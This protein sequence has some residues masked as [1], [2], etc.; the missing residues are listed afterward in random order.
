MLAGILLYAVATLWVQDRWAVCGLQAA[1]FLCT[2]WV[3]LR[4]ALWRLP[5]VGGVIPALFAGMCLWAVTQRAA[6]W[7]VVPAD[8]ADASL[9]WL[10][11]ACLAWL[12]LQACAA[13]QERRA[14]LKTALS[15]GSAV[16]LL[17]LV[18]LFTSNGLVFW[19]FPSGYD[20]G[21]VGPFVSR[22][23]YAALVELLLPV[24]LVLAFRRGRQAKVYWVLA[25]ALVAS[26]IASGSRAGTSIVLGEATLAFLLK[27]RT[28]RNSV[29]R[30]SM[31]FVVLVPAFTLIVGYQYVWQRLSGDKNPFEFRREFVESSVA[32]VRAEPLHGFGLGTWPSAYRQY[33]VIDAGSPANHSHNEWVQWAAEGGLPA[34]GL[35]LA[36]AALCVPGSIRS[37]WGLGVLAGFLH[38]LV[39]YPFFRLG[40]AAWIFV[41][42]G[43]LAG[44][45]RERRR[46][47]RGDCSPPRLPGPQARGVAL[48]LIPILA[49]AAC[50]SFRTA[51]ADSLYRRAT[52]AGVTRAGYLRPDRAEYQFA[53]A[54]TD[55]EHAIQHLQR[56]IVLNPFLTDARIILA[57]QLEAEGDAAGSEAALLEL[58]RRDRQYA[59][60]W[61]LANYYFRAG[62]PE[63]FWHWANAAAQVSPGGV[64]PLF[65][66]CFA[67]TDDSAIVLN[68]V[69]VPRRI[70]E[71]EYLAFLIERNRL[72]DAHQVALRIAVEAGPEDRDSLL[73]YVDR[74]LEAGRFEGAAAL[75]NELCR[76]RLGPYPPLV[77]GTL[78]NGDFSQPILNHGFDWRAG[79][80]GCALAA[81]TNTD[82]TALELFLSGKRPE[83]CEVYYQYL[84]LAAGA[85]YV[86]SFQYRTREL[87]DLTGLR[88]S[89]G[90]GQDYEFRASP[91]WSN[92]EWQWRAAKAEG[93]LILVCRRSNGSTRH[94]GTVLVRRVRLEL[95]EMPQL[96]LVPVRPG[97]E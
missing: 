84:R 80:P 86:L 1:V 26:V 59:P 47:E 28:D 54:Q 67:V 83:N 25:A 6:H 41:F 65:E 97:G 82:G 36:A 17:G 21:V 29:G 13:R 51:W 75:W 66:L 45:G 69:V 12:G 73:D 35:M 55:P 61:A 76:R 15:V 57:S 58:A 96:S 48:A 68:R 3:L 27:T 95:N 16:C 70:V 74:A 79:A 64:R 14:L 20:S 32:M 40:L 53:L 37:I 52:A 30:S 18:Q 90:T 72:S 31:V 34:L 49:F 93:R 56:A 87:P 39:D 62:R 71:R 50:Q 10:A 88:W 44:Y 33:A 11:A 19:L 63:S 2:A 43:A 9:Y 8:T 7:T 92:G 38:S 42:I 81:Q 46:L 60:A 94:E 78:V 85:H 5:T 91:E 4:V 22:N 24:A 77:P 89:L 23:N